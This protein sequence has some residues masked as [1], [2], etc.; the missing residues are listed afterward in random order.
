MSDPFELAHAM[1]KMSHPLNHLVVAATDQ[2][3]LIGRLQEEV[4]QLRFERDE[5]R[6]NVC[7]QMLLR[8]V[9]FSRVGATSV[10]VT[11]ESEVASMMNW[12]CFKEETP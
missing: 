5:A 11:K 10:A 8:G 6:R 3:Y 12:D 9:V 1:A 2:A 4:K 7:R